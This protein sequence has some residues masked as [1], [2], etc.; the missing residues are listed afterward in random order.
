MVWAVPDLSQIVKAYD[1][2]GVVP[3][4]LDTGVAEAG[5][6]AFARG[7][8][9]AQG[10]LGRD[11]RP[12]SPELAAAFAA[13]ANGQGANVVDIGLA[14]TDQ[15]YFA[16]GSL[17]VPAAIFTASHTPARYNAIHL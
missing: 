9:A 17:D 1:I 16:S 7:T 5:G 14:S 4:Q 15:L 10:A 13:G 11:M 6:A 3:D 8:A 2:R 12:S